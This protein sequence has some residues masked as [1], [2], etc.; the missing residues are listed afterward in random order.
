[1]N[2]V[3]CVFYVLLCCKSKGS[4]E[5]PVL[6]NLYKILLDITVVKLQSQPFLNDLL[7]EFRDNSLYQVNGL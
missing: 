1:M 7:D 4:A 3:C 6:K 5:L 2:K